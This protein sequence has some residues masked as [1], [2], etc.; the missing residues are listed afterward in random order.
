MTIARTT[1]LCTARPVSRRP[2]GS[3]LW[4]SAAFGSS[5]SPA[6]T[7]V[8]S[9]GSP[10]VG[11]HVVPL[12]PLLVKVEPPPVPLPE[13]VLPPHPKAALTRAKL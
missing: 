13:V 8:K 11:R 5:S 1:R 4:K 2:A 12:P 7:V 10:V 9:R 6:S 3:A